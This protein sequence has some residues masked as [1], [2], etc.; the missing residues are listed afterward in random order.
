MSGV[1]PCRVWE[2][3]GAWAG[4]VQVGVGMAEFLGDHK[5]DVGEAGK[6]CAGSSGCP[7]PGD[8]VCGSDVGGL[9]RDSRFGEGGVGVL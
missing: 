6:F 8:R 5:G 7:V 3:S 9:G 4:G 2:G 1:V